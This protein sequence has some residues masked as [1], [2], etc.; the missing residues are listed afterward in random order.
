LTYGIDLKDDLA[1]FQIII[2]LPFLPLGSKRI[3]KMFESD[4]VWYENK[5]LNA[6]VQACG[7]ATR[8]K[9]D[10]SVTYILDG[11]FINVLRNAKNKLPKY[12]ID[13]IH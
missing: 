2:K 4:K 8:S 6:I 12:F 9:D 5:M 1:R 13:R 7:R 11:N 3:K 10:H